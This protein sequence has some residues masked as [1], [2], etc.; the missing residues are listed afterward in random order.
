M[1][2][3]N[4]EALRGVLDGLDLEALAAAGLEAGRS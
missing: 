2:K 3:E 4:L 1:S